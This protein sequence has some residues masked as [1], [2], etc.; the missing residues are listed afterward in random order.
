M[1]IQ[2]V[3]H[4]GQLNLRPYLFAA[5][6]G[7]ILSGTDAC[8][9]ASAL[10][11]LLHIHVDRPHTWSQTTN[12]ISTSEQASTFYSET[13]SIS[14]LSW[15]RE[16]SCIV[17]QKNTR[18]DCNISNTIES[19]D[20]IHHHAHTPRPCGNYLRWLSMSF[21]PSWNIPNQPSLQQQFYMNN[22]DSE[23]KKVRK[24]SLFLV[25]WAILLN[26]HIW[27]SWESRNSLNR[28]PFA[29]S[30]NCLSQS[31]QLLYFKQ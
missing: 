4:R 23:S 7:C 24:I 9:A 14:A 5:T 22:K 10:N 27:R 29:L 20:A 8:K 15:T 25:I 13:L 1:A 18:R 19:F 17:N 11:H 21:Q 16:G 6:V 28:Q 12:C 26:R 30:S 31:Y 2:Q 3:G